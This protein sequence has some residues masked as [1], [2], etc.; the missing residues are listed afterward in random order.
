M[1]RGPTGTYTEIRSRSSVDTHGL[2]DDTCTHTVFNDINYPSQVRLPEYI[3]KVN[4]SKLQM[5]FTRRDRIFLNKE[6]D[7]K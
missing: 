4:I 2:I 7:Y 1:F 5:G 6:V 3:R